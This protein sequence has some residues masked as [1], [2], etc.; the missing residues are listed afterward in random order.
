MLFT[1]QQVNKM[2]YPLIGQQL[3]SISVGI[4]DSMMVSTAGEAAISGVSLIGVLNTLLMML[5]SAFSSG[6]AIVL[7]LSIGT[8]D[9]DKSRN[10]AKQLIWSCF[11]VALA[12]SVL[13]VAFRIP[14]LDLIYGDTDAL[15]MQNARDYFFYLALA[16]PFL[17]V[18]NGIYAIFNAMGNTKVSL[19][20]SVLANGVNIVGNAVLIYGFKMG[21]A[22]A[23]IATSLSWVV[24]A[25][26]M[27][28]RIHN[29]NHLV[30]VE[31]IFKI[32]PDFNIIKN[33]CAVGIPNG[34]ENSMFQFGKLLTQSLVASFALSQITANSVANSV[35]T[36]QYGIGGAIASAMVTIVGRCIGAGEKEQ[37]K[38]YSG[39]LLKMMYIMTIVISVLLSVFSKQIADIYNLSGETAYIT[40]NLLIFHSI[41]AAVVWPSSFTLPNAFRAAKD[42]QFTMIISVVSMWIFRVYLS[43]VLGRDMGLGVMGV[44]YAMVCDWVFRA[45]IFVIRYIRG[46]WLKKYQGE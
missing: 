4:I 44:W 21:A 20:N 42:V 36:L 37:A 41:S 27:M 43:Y 12:V 15:V 25:V 32:K 16:Y 3:L 18:S 23:A 6:G 8:N 13:S 34:V 17:A 19:Y 30:Y 24:S 1:R 45:I 9:M 11:G 33:I 40:M 28:Y 26:T 22:G 29:K 2:V 31:K 7:S 46:T 10:V 14:L 38:Y 39:Y 35:V 5:F